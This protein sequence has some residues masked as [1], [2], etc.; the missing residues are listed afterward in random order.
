M[1][2]VLRRAI[3]ALEAATAPVVED[4]ETSAITEAARKVFEE[5]PLTRAVPPPL[6]WRHAVDDAVKLALAGLQHTP[7]AAGT[8]RW[9]EVPFGGAGEP[10]GPIPPGWDP[11]RPVAL[12][13]LEV[14]GRID[15]LDLRAAG[16]AARAHRLE[17][18]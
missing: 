13:G 17:D 2:E 18:R 10:S 16:N 14:G 7:V 8:T 4:C 11:G 9:T 5:W 6:P 3:D 1:H 15:R 12:G